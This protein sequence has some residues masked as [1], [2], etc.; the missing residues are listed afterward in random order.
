M[1][2]KQDFIDRIINDPI[3]QGSL[4]KLSEDEK[5]EAIADATQIAVNI[6]NA[7]LPLIQKIDETTLV[8]LKE[9]INKKR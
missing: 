3:F 7:F 2:T 8:L 1:K 6:S 5:K 9:E 4:L